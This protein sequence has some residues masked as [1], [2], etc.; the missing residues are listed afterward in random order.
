[1]T[2]DGAAP[3]V[4]EVVT[5]AP[6]WRRVSRFVSGKDVFLAYARLDGVQYVIALTKILAERIHR[7]WQT[8]GA[9]SRRLTI[10]RPGVI[11]GLAE[12]GNF[13]RLA[14]ALKHR[15][16]VFPGRTDTIKAHG[17]GAQQQHRLTLDATGTGTAFYHIRPM[18]GHIAHLST[19][20]DLTIEITTS[21]R[22]HHF[23][24]SLKQEFS[25]FR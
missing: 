6:A 4:G 19:G 23:K 13:T 3:E 25:F 24:Q 22:T 1:M 9:A 12:G 18:D 17:E 11:Y 2:S 10:V 8:E 15:R 14:R 7:L 16:F 20:Q 21:G 5:R